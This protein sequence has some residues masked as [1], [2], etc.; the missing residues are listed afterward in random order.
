MTP[1]YYHTPPQPVSG[2]VRCPICHEAVYSRAG[3]HPQCA[4]RQSDPP[5]PKNKPKGESG[6]NEQG[7]TAV[8]QV[9]GVAVTRPPTGFSVSASENSAAAPSVRRG[10]RP[11]TTGSSVNG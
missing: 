2:R 6:D 11:G 7:R 3:I 10:V 8:E 9:G 5:K 1:K 4:V